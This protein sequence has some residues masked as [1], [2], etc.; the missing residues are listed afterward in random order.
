VGYRGPKLR[1]LGS[2]QGSHHESYKFPSTISKLAAKV[3]D[4]KLLA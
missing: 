1:D 4:R 3:F 2:A